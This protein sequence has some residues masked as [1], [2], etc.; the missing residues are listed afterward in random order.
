LSDT[1]YLVEIVLL[2]KP[3]KYKKE[4]LAGFKGVIGKKMISQMKRENILCPVLGN[5]VGF[6]FCY[7]CPSFLRR[8]RGVVHCAGGEGPK[9]E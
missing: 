9:L 6:L 2:E 1:K 4:T 5:N 3:L 8:V 7:N